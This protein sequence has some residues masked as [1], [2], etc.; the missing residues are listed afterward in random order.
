MPDDKDSKPTSSDAASAVKAR[1]A[2][3][4]RGR[5]APPPESEP[6]VST[7]NL[8]VV[9]TSIGAETMIGSFV[10]GQTASADYVIAPADAFEAHYPRGCM[11]PSCVRLWQ[12]GQQVH[13][14]YFDAHG[15]VNAAR[16]PAEAKPV[17]EPGGGIHSQAGLT[18]AIK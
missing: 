1:R 14:T 5:Q 11:Q 16:T 8:G 15:G 13:R 10:A 2:G 7:A 6:T 3:A 17:N 18:T 9:S 12:R 4:P